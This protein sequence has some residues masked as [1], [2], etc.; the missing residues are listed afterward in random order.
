MLEEVK[1]ADFGTSWSLPDIRILWAKRRCE[2]FSP[3]ITGPRQKCGGGYGS[4]ELITVIFTAFLQKGDAF[5]TLEPDF[6][7]YAFQR[8]PSRKCAM[9]SS[10][11]KED[12][13]LDIDR[14]IETCNNEGV[15]L[16]I[17]S[18]PATRPLWCRAGGNAEADPR[19]GRPW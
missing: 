2:A 18:N 1:A 16:L 6:S 4:D 3:A 14:V 9:L 8:I 11:K 13:T 10:E 5:A 15:K 19:C 12:F 7:M 17:F